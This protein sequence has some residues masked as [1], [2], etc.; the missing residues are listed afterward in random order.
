MGKGTV[1]VRFVIAHPPKP[2]QLSNTSVVPSLFGIRARFCGR[3]F[4]H[5][6][7]VEDVF[8][9]IQVHYIYCVLYFCYYYISSTSDHQASDARGKK[10]V[11][12][13]CLTKLNSGNGINIEEN[14]I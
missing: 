12:R 4:S 14:A 7:G 13:V 5:K 9:M 8:K 10:Q 1:P 3:Q 2:R 11:N 6:P